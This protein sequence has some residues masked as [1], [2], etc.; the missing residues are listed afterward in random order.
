MISF[1][2]HGFSEDLDEEISRNERMWILNLKRK[3][4]FV[5]ISKMMIKGQSQKN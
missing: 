4:T 1:Q 2:V 5:E 3:K